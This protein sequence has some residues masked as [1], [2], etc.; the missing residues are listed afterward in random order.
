[1]S[2][3]IAVSGSKEQTAKQLADAIASLTRAAESLDKHTDEDG[4]VFHIHVHGGPN[5]TGHS[6]DKTPPNWSPLP[7]PLVP[8]GG[9]PPVNA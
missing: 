8:G 1:M 3:S 4:Y 9:N 7:G 6:I 5:G 2:W